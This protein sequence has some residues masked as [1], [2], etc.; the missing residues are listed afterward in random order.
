MLTLKFAGLFLIISFI[1]CNQNDDMVEEEP[2]SPLVYD[3]LEHIYGKYQI[4]GVGEWEAI[5]DPISGQHDSIPGTKRIA[6][7]FSYPIGTKQLVSFENNQRIFLG[8]NNQKLLIQNF[9]TLDYLS[10]DV[11]DLNTN[12]TLINP[13]HIFFGKTEDQIFILDND[14]SLWKVDIQTNLVEI[15]FEN[16]VPDNDVNVT[17][18]FYLKDS[19]DFLFT[20]N[21]SDFGVSSDPSATEL[22]LYDN[23]VDSIIH[24]KTIQR[25]FG[26]VRFPKEDQFFYLTYPSGQVGFKLMNVKVSGSELEIT[27]K[28]T[29]K[30]AIDSLSGYLQTIHSATN[31]YICRGGSNLIEAPTNI[32]YSIDLTTGE[33]TNEATL[34]DSGIMSNLASE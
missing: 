21:N 32:L 1:S 20:T 9:S 27:T 22:M 19:D 30:L 13:S 3:P 18:I 34:T 7:G 26:F 5:I 11:K 28:S 25:G 17:N 10:I 8:S 12:R 33:L 15:E 29:S 2:L 16:I 14:K 4:F 24:T 31:K 23:D 6:G